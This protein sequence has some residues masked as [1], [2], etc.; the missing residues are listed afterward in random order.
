[1]RA[2]VRDVGQFQQTLDGAIFAEGTVKHGEDD[3]DIDGA[4]DCPPSQGWAPYLKRNNASAF[5]MRGFGW[6]H[7]SLALGQDGGPRGD[8]GIAS[9]QVASL[10][11]RFAIEQAFCMIGG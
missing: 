8:L 6:N 10:L 9:A 4:I 11:D 2:D 7:D 3:V 5:A 1:A